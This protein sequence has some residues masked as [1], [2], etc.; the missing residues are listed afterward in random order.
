MVV[1]LLNEFSARTLKQCDSGPEV[2]MAA[3]D[4]ES[5]HN[6]HDCKLLFFMKGGESHGGSMTGK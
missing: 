5:L 1:G 4:S 6:Y 3:S 2:N